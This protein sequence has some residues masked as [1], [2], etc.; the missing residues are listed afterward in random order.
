VVTLPH[1]YED[2]TLGLSFA[3]R[4]DVVVKSEY[5]V[6][7]GRLIE[8]EKVPLAPGFGPYK[9]NYYMLSVSASF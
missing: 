1:L 7:K 5:H 6:V 2:T 3:F 8:D 4:P 9:G